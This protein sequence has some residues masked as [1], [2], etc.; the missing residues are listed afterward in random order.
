MTPSLIFI[1]VPLSS[2]YPL[3][4]FSSNQTPW[5]VLAFYDSPHRGRCSC[6]KFAHF[7]LVSLYVI[8]PDDD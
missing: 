7:K 6:V 2:F 4:C 8:P 1:E 5:F 3:A